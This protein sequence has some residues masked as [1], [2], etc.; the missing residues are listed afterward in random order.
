[1]MT[2]TLYFSRADDAIDFI[3]QKARRNLLAKV[4]FCV[5]YRLMPVR[6]HKRPHDQPF[7]LS[8]LSSLLDL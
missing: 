4:D 8:C 7:Y 3:A 6:F 5:A 2:P 1:M